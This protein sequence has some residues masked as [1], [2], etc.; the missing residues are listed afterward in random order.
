MEKFI[1]ISWYEWLY[2]I[3]EKYQLLDKS[4]LVETKKENNMS[5]STAHKLF[6]VSTKFIWKAKKQP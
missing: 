3:T 4:I 1:D 2:M 6:L 5:V